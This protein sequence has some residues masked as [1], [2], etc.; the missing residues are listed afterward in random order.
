MS[1]TK[2]TKGEWQVSGDGLNVNSGG[3]RVARAYSGSNIAYVQPARANA[4]LI[5]AAPEMY[6]IIANIVKYSKLNDSSVNEYT[7][8]SI[9][10]FEKLLAKARGEN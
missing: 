7:H 10:S 2:F 9:L 3:C 4:H 1:E 6:A 8:N 5:A